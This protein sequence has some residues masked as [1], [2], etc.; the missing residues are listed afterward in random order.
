VLEAYKKENF[1]KLRDLL[2]EDKR[3]KK[4]I[5][6]KFNEYS[7]KVIEEKQKKE[8]EL[9]NKQLNEV[10]TDIAKLLYNT[11]IT[12]SI[13]QQSIKFNFEN[14]KAYISKYLENNKQKLGLDD[15]EVKILKSFDSS[16]FNLKDEGEK[17]KLITIVYESILPKI[18]E[19]QYN[20]Y[21]KILKEQIEEMQRKVEDA[22]YEP[23]ISKE[24]TKRLDD[25]LAQEEAT[26]LIYNYDKLY[27][28]ITGKKPEK[29]GKTMKK[30]TFKGR[31]LHYGQAD[32]SQGKI[33][34]ENLNQNEQN[35]INKDDGNEQDT[36]E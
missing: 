25:L 34:V 27:K 23:R 6:K 32:F 22:K 26:R 36:M 18:K 16:L 15:N 7:K 31:P 30:G 11:D 9:Y 21:A 5:V 4:I 2:E 28:I 13:K 12:S 10:K 8:D 19:M 29:V 1:E 33:R 35:I 3:T 17:R 24:E 20:N 14:M